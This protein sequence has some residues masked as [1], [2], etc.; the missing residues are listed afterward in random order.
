MYLANMKEVDFKFE[1]LKVYQKALD[2]VDKV[3]DLTSK[4]PSKEE[5]RLTS[6]Y[7]RAATSIALNIAEGAGDTNAQFNRFLQISQ[8]S[9]K[10]CIV[11]SS[12]ALRQNYITESENSETR[13]QLIEIAKMI[14]SLQ[15]YLKNQ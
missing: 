8:G 15:K 6:Q 1:E 2:Y 12:I 10:E 14:T 5:Y 3:Y 9:I 7:I 13:K 4:F 11:C